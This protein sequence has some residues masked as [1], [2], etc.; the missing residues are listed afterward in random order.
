MLIIAQ[1]SASARSSC[2]SASA[3]K[4]A[5]EQSA[6][7]AS[8][9]IRATKD[10]RLVVTPY[11]HLD[12]D[13]RKPKIRSL[14]LKEIRRYSA[15]SPHPMQTI[16]EALATLLG[17]VFVEIRFQERSAIAPLLTALAPYTAR[18]NGWKNFLL[19]ADNPFILLQLRRVAPHAQLGLRHRRYPLTFL[20]WQPVLQLSAVGLHRLHTTSVAVEAAHTLDLFVYAYTVNRTAALKKLAELDVDAVASDTPEKLRL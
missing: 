4:H 19:S 20:T 16:D 13:R 9:N 17:T 1:H 15:G 10:N 12:N 6:H 8:I 5:V 3:L 7:M 18:K 11:V 14:T 2:C